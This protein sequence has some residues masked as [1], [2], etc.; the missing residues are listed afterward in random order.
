MSG[1]LHVQ[2]FIHLNCLMHTQLSSVMCTLCFSVNSKQ[3]FVHEVPGL[4][5][6]PHPDSLGYKHRNKCCIIKVMH[7]CR[8][9]LCYTNFWN[10]SKLQ[11]RFVDIH[12]V[13]NLSLF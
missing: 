1:I 3:G 2:C 13:Q 4:E 8:F 10:F 7:H 5:D 6:D 9:V 11:T 12:C